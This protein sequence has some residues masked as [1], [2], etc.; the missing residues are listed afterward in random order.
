[1][2]WPRL[3]VHSVEP[4]VDDPIGG[5]RS[6]D[7]PFQPPV[8]DLSLV[9]DRHPVSRAVAERTAGEAMQHE[10]LF[11][12]T[13]SGAIL[14]AAREFLSDQGG[15][16]VALLPDDGWKYLSGPPWASA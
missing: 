13:S 1:M 2:K 9:T 15:T 14:H 4:Y 16:A 8:A 7:D 10:G 6:Q 3:R 11:P 12:G 5:M